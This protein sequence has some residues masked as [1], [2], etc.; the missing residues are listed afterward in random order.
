MIDVNNVVRN[1]FDKIILV[2]IST[3]VCFL[4]VNYRN[5]MIKTKGHPDYPKKLM[6]VA[7]PDDETIFG[8]SHLINDKYVV[9]CV[10]CGVKKSRVK[11]FKKVMN[12]SEDDYIML[13]YPD[14]V[15]GK[16][17]KWKKEYSHIEKDIQN[18]IE[19]NDWD[20]IVTHN[21]DGEY[22]HI[23]HKMISKIVTKYAN[24]DKLYYFGHY[25]KKKELK[26]QKLIEIDNNN[27]KIKTKKM[28]EEY[29]TQTFVK[30]E[31]GHMFKYE[32]WVKYKDW[33]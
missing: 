1:K 23:H 11:E 13:D 28:I 22:G 26:K 15:H 20:I 14:K 16:R 24:N 17:S 6:I 3:T 4:Y 25:Y 9:V 7:H 8:G 10:T 12:I 18:I 2:L 30:K 33:N 29:K 27:Y 31:F 21:P 32:N 19:S 5:D